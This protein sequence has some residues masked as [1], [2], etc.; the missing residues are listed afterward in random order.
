MSGFLLILE[1]NFFNCFIILESRSRANFADH[2]F[3]ALVPSIKAQPSFLGLMG[4]D[5][6]RQK[7]QS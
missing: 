2:K 3:D 1:M 5:L 6:G 7:A 4:W